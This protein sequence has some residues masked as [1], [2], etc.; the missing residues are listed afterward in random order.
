V[1]HHINKLKEKQHMIISLNAK[2]DFDK[3]QHPLIKDLVRLGVQ[4]TYLNIIKTV[5]SQPI[6]DIN[7]NGEKVKTIPLKSGTRRGFQSLNLFNLVLVILARA[8]IQTKEMGGGTNRKR[9]SKSII[10]FK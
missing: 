4:W 10:I 6:I 3:I 7:L 9:R 8:I 5:Y 1:I 2:K